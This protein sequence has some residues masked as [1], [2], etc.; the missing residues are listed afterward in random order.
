VLFRFIKAKD[1]YIDS[2]HFDKMY[3]LDEHINNK[4]LSYAIRYS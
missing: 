2:T 1:E 3:F 4:L